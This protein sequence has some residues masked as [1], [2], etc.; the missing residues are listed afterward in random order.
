MF[1]SNPTPRRLPAATRFSAIAAALL[2]VFALQPVHAQS[3][4]LWTQSRVDEFEK[5]TQQG[6]AI[7]SDGHLH[8]GPGLT[9]ILTTPSS[10][11]W[12]IAAGKNGESYLGTSSP[13]TVLR[14]GKDGKPVTLFETKDVSVQVLRIGPDGALYAATMPSG[15][16]YRLKPDATEKQDESN[17]TV[18]FDLGKLDEEKPSELK[19][20]EKTADKKDGEDKTETKS[21]Y[22]WDMTFDASG[23]LYIATGGPGAVYRI[24]P[25]KPAAAPEPFFKSDEEH[26]RCLAWDAKGNLIAGT[27]GH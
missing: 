16:V 2:A 12:S 17:A 10:F 11:V 13:A 3:T 6:V 20:S 5:G 27:D 21:H 1:V 9:E 18:V 19:A 15:K 8:E 23:H 4:H 7:S 22:I 26:I 14:V 25:A 24:D